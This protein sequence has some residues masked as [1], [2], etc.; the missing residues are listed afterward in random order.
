[1]TTP[2][3]IPDR[4][5]VESPN[6]KAVA[7]LHQ[8]GQLA[9]R[10]T[11]IEEEKRGLLEER[12]GLYLRIIDADPNLPLKEVARAA[13][14]SVPAVIQQREAARASRTTTPPEEPS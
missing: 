14:V 13:G 9:E 2:T 5:E 6:E 10:L 1:M 4:P 11:A 3:A 8:L 7:L 12:R